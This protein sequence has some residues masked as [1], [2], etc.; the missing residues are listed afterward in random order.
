MKYLIKIARF[1][2]LLW[3]SA[4]YAQ[5]SQFSQMETLPMLANPATTG[6]FTNNDINIGAQYRNQWS[7][8]SSSINTFALSF[9]MPMTDR[10]SVGG[11]IKNTD[12]ISI[13]NSF[14]F[15]ASGSYIITNPKN[16]DYILSTGLQLG[17]IYKRINTG[18]LTFDSQYD[19]NYFNIDLPSGENFIRQ[20]TMIPDANLGFYYR[21][22]NRKN[23]F[24]PYG[25]LSVF[26]LFY[27]NETFLDGS[28]GKLP[29]R[30]LIHAGT[31]IN[32]NQLFEMEVNTFYQMQ[33]DFT[34]LLINV[35]AKYN[36][37]RSEY[38]IVG[39]IGWR[40]QDALIVHAGFKHGNNTFRFSYDFNI[41]DLKS[42]TR[43]R[44]AIEFSVLYVA[45][46]KRGNITSRF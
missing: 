24:N 32:F 8:L 41:S 2:F 40:Y 16:R 19:Q 39:G 17:F 9:D 21:N 44:G 14:N 13:I 35:Y 6:V 37:D 10:W 43:N 11:Y 1:V 38:K 15:V 22:I 20:N 42:Y 46:R 31:G 18:N 29:L 36:I 25:G 7:S 28:T 45:G 5:D 30:Y 27:A 34:Q 3:F 26:H 33:R 23:Q 12:E 4:G